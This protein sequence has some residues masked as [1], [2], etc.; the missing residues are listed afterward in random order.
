MNKSTNADALDLAKILNSVVL[1]RNLI[2]ASL[3]LAA[4]E[5]LNSAVLEETKSFYNRFGEKSEITDS[6]YKEEV[7]SLDKDELTAS[8]RWL[9]DHG[10]IDDRDLVSYHEIR[11][12]RNVV[13]HELPRLIATAGSDI[14]K[15][16]LIRI[17]EL[18][19][20]IERWWILE[21]E[22]PVNPDFDDQTVQ[23][24]DITTGRMTLLKVILGI[25]Q[26]ED[27]R[28]HWDEIQRLLMRPV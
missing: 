9:K 6:R 3:Y 20:R 21:F 2:S 24:E 8:W 14:S 23:A 27:D 11:A 22:V 13:A 15:P 26:A 12:H 17:A 1:K 4:Y 10:A 5:I 19:D 25:A 16:L 28:N 18:L 7:R